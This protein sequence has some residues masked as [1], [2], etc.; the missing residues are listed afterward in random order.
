M[1]KYFF[2][3]FW[4]DKNRKK[5]NAEKKEVEKRRGKELEKKKHP[6]ENAVKKQ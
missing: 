4:Q 5:R 1:S 3:F 6:N 2:L